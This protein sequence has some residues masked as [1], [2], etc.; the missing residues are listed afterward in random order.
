MTFGK[1]M[2]TPSRDAPDDTCPYCRGQGA[3][4]ARGQ[5]KVCVPCKGTGTKPTA[6]PE[7]EPDEA[8]ESAVPDTPA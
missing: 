5:R 8:A 3:I 6:P 4:R 7:P 2:V 1:R